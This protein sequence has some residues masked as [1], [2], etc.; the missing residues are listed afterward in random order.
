MSNRWNLMRSKKGWILLACLFPLFSCVSIR[1]VIS[2]PTP[3]PTATA[4]PTAT[5]TP[6]LTPTSTRLPLAERDLKDL[7]LQASDLPDGFMEVDLPNLETLFEQMEDELKM[8]SLKNLE[9]G[10]ACLF[11]SKENEAYANLI[12]IL[13]DTGY[14]E[15][16]YDEYVDQ[17]NGDEMDVPLIGEE[18]TGFNTSNG[19]LTGYLIVWRYQEAVVALS[20]SGESEKDV[21]EVLRLA[22]VVQSRIE[23][24]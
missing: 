12:F 14:A 21:E 20:Y 6:T 16:A 22:E 4:T 13:S 2:P 15:I 18:S 1:D 23:D 17:A 24:V 8:E 11:S 7:A 19:S 9:V 10:F 3:T 5:N